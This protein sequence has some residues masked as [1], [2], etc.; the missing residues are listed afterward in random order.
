MFSELMNQLGYLCGE[1]LEA[2]VN[3]PRHSE[4]EA[5]VSATDLKHPLESAAVLEVLT[6]KLLSGALGESLRG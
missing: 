4:S 1:G 5:R 6:H 2:S 3:S